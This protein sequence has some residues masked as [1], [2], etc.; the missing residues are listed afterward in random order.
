MNWSERDIEKLLLAIFNGTFSGARLPKKLYL[1]T[2]KQLFSAVETVFGGDV[3]SFVDGSPDRLLLEHFKYN[4]AIFS[5]AKTHQ[6]VVDITNE[7]FK[8]GEKQSFS[9]FKKVAGTIFQKY[10]VN[11]LKT[12]FNMAN[13]QAIAGRK[14]LDIEK[15]K[16]IFPALK[17][18]TI[19]DERVRADHSILDG[20]VRPVDDPFWRT[21]YPPNDW[22]CRCTVEQMTAEESPISS[23]SVIKK[24]NEKYQPDDLFNGNA[25][26]DRIIF[27]PDHPYF[28]VDD[29]FK[30][31]KENNFNLPTPKKPKRD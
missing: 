21:Y 18:V 7:I 2:Y 22:G 8:D 27:S 28:K 4:V 29:R 23:D 9:E 1:D 20:I 14:W 30:L 13:N 31:L 26:I 17:Y 16:D 15:N 3:E 24:I 19:G 5:G 11:W 25:G 12:E 6:N 10:N